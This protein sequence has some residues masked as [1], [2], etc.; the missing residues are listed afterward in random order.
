MR[1]SNLLSPHSPTYGS[2]LFPLSSVSPCPIVLSGGTRDSTVPLVVRFV[3]RASP[4]S[5]QSPAT[6]FIRGTPSRVCW[7]QKTLLPC[8]VVANLSPAQF[9][10]T[11]PYCPLWSHWYP[12]FSRTVCSASPS[13]VCTQIIASL[14]CD[15]CLLPSGLYPLVI[16][17]SNWRVGPLWQVISVT[18]PFYG[19]PVLLSTVF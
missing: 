13:D 4:C 15:H 3:S 5:L 16:D 19:S 12:N 8:S 9:V 7:C 6:R 14:F 17:D 18:S 10:G 2:R 1:Y 11:G